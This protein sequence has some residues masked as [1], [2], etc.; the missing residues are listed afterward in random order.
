MR[1]STLCLAVL[2]SLFSAAPAFAQFDLVTGQVLDPNGFPYSGAT[3]KAQLTING[4]NVTGQPT[5]T[6]TSQAQCTSAGA[7]TAPCQ[8]PFPGTVGPVTLDA[9]GNIPGGGI[10]L[11]DNPSVTPAGT[12][13]TFSVTI[14]PG[15]LPPL[16]TGPQSFSLAITINA[17][18]Q[19]VGGLLSAV[20]PKLSNISGG[21]GG[22]GTVTS[23]SSGNF[24]PL[25]T[26]SVATASSTPALSFTGVSQNA[27][28]FFA[29][30]ATGSAA[31]PTF[32]AMVA[33][34]LAATV[35]NCAAGSFAIGL[36]SGGVPICVATTGGTQT[37]ASGTSQA[38]T[39]ATILS[40]ACLGTVISAPGVLATDMLDVSGTQNPPSVYSW[41]NWSNSFLSANTVN[42][43]VCNPDSSSSHVTTTNAVNW[44]VLR[45][46]SGGGGSGVSA[47]NTL[48]GAVTLAAGSGVTL[49]P[50]GNTIT[51]ASTGGGGATPVATLPGTC[52]AGTQYLL[53]NNTVVNCGPGNNQFLTGTNNTLLA[54]AFGVTGGGVQV[55]DIST[56]NG[57]PNVASAGQAT[58]CNGATVPCLNNQPSSVGQTIVVWKTCISNGNGN[59]GQVVGN[60]TTNPTI[61]SVTDS[62]HVV[63]SA[64]A[65]A[66]VT[67]T[68][69][70][71]W[72]PLDDAGF[73][74]LATYL[75]ALTSGPCPH[76][77]LPQGRMLITA[78]TLNTQPPAC[79]NN[80]GTAGGTGIQGGGLEVSGAGIGAS[81]LVPLPAFNYSTCTSGVSHFT[82]FNGI[83]YSIFHDFTISG[84]GLST[85]AAPTD[86]GFGVRAGAEAYNMTFF[87]W[88]LYSN[89]FR[90]WLSDDSSSSGQG[91]WYNV[92]NDGFG[93]ILLN[94]LSGSSFAGYNVFISDGIGTG[95]NSMVVNQGIIS[96]KGGTNLILWG[97]S[98]IT[99]GGAAGL[100]NFGTVNGTFSISYSSSSPNTL[101]LRLESNSVTTFQPGSAITQTGSGAFDVYAV[102][103]ITGAKLTLQGTQLNSVSS[104]IRCGGTG[105]VVVNDLGGNTGLGSCG[106]G[107][108]G[109]TFI[110]T[111]NSANAVPVAAS[112]LVLSAGWGSTATVTAVQGATAPVGFTITNSGTGQAASP[113]ITYTFPT[114]YAIAPISC[115]ATDLSGTNPLLNP[116]TTSSLTAT[117]A[118]FTATGTPTVSDT[119]VMQI[120]CV[121]P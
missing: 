97:N 22:G 30:P 2:F 59:Y 121:A 14:S 89:G 56:T 6:V 33:A 119:E 72:G 79:L 55:T 95:G 29:G 31:L 13:W 110:N 12:Q 46:G 7:G 28:L 8:V 107:M 100:D 116:F 41:L 68:G 74:A 19:N 9:N 77:V 84:D 23:F 71:D 75:A 104:A 78:A 39:N 11:A 63:A 52:A 5:V 42:I 85:V 66:T 24:S 50:S 3:L 61:L 92:T 99:G 120:T 26:T 16:G 67:S 20:A 48:T 91:H 1:R 53:P 90:G 27:N 65:T 103:G 60:T 57:S 35:S 4:S 76:V 118:V 108:T 102:P 54:S 83:F 62:H 38:L 87:N 82:C 51:I 112:G 32:R 96:L 44:I 17:N 69:C 86:A 94:V 117:G 15:A 10:N 105:A 88:N 21:G 109:A 47:L 98:A 25:F 101:G 113:T 93:S 106:A 37:I 70:A 58:W 81:V 36:N 34:D 64:N 111:A 18:P 49:T 40:G 73:S 115:T 45:P 43:I 114:A 80:P